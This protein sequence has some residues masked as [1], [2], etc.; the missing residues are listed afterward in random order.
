MRY[1]HTKGF[2]LKQIRKLEDAIK[3]L[4]NECDRILKGEFT[5]YKTDVYEHSDAWIIQK[6]RYNRR[7]IK[8]CKHAIT[9]YKTKYC[10]D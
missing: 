3:K 6:Y 1:K 4:D 10:I 2:A 5:G 9:E 7:M 8:E